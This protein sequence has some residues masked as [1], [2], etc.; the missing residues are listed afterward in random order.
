MGDLT[1]LRSCWM[2]HSVTPTPAPIRA[3]VTLPRVVLKN[4]LS[5]PGAP[6]GWSAA[7]HFDE[8]RGEADRAAVASTCRLAGD[9]RVRGPALLWA[10]D[11]SPPP[12]TAAPPRSH[13]GAQ[14]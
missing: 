13:L 1:G 10:G 9:R 6:A 4:E 14:A 11:R 7:L 2:D 12:R 8:T 5:P 3:R